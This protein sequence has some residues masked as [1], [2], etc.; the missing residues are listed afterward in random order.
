MNTWVL[1]YIESTEV[2]Y[3]LAQ[4]YKAWNLTLTA[5]KTSSAWDIKKDQKDLGIGYNYYYYCLHTSIG[6]GADP[7]V[8]NTGHIPP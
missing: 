7:G 2:P 4:Q 8:G 1:L 6:T 5:S 3:A